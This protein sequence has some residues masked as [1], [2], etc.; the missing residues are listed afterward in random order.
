MVGARLINQHSSEPQSNH[1]DVERAIRA[2]SRSVGQM[3]WYRT[4]AGGALLLTEQTEYIEEKN[5]RSYRRGQ[6]SYN[7]VRLHMT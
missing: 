6:R 1:S 2:H 3:L 7:C 4:V 5:L